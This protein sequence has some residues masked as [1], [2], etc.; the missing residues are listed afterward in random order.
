MRQFA[1]T[2]TDQKP[3]KLALER[4]QAIAGKV[5]RLRRCGLIEAAQNVFYVIQQIRPYPAPVVAFKKPFQAPVF[6]AS[7]HRDTP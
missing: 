7:D 5:E 6:E 1:R 2:V 3:R 4:M